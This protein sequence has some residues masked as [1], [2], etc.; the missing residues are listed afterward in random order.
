[1]PLGTLLRLLVRPLKRTPSKARPA[2]RLRLEVLEGRTMPSVSTWVGGAHGDATNWSNA[3]NWSNGVPGANDTAYFPRLDSGVK[4]DL[5]VL[6][7]PAKVANLLIDGRWKSYLQLNASLEVRN[8]FE[9]GSGSLGGTGRLTIDHT[10][11]WSAGLLYGSGALSVLDG[12]T[13]TIGSSATRELRG[14]VIDNAG[15]VYLRD[16]AT[17]LFSSNSTF[18]NHADA[19]FRIT[20]RGTF[21][22]TD[23]PNPAFVN[24]GTVIADTGTETAVI[25]IPFGDGLAGAVD[26]L[27]G[28]LSLRD[29]GK[30]SGVFR[31]EPAGVLEF[32]GGTHV[33]DRFSHV[34]GPGHVRFGRGGTAALRGEY[35]VAATDILGG[36]ADFEAAARTSSATLDNLLFGGNLAGKGTLVVTRSFDWRGGSMT[37]GGTT[38]ITPGATLTLEGARAKNLNA[39][40]IENYGAAVWKDAGDLLWT[41]VGTFDNHAGATFT[42]LNDARMGRADNPRPKFVNDGTFVKAGGLGATTIDV[43]FDDNGSVV[44]AVGSIVFSDGG[45]SKGTFAIGPVGLVTFTG[46][47]ATW[48]AGTKFTGAG[49]VR[50]SGATVHI[51]GA[52]AVANLILDRSSL[53]GPGT[54]VVSKSFD[55]NGG[56]LRN[57]GSL[58]IDASATATL[59]GSAEKVLE[60]TALN[61]AGK[62]V[63]ADAGNLRLVS[64]ASVNVLAGGSLTIDGGAVLGGTGTFANAGQVTKA[65]GGAT[66]LRVPFTNR[67]TLTLGRG[68]VLVVDGGFQQ[69]ATGR[70]VLQGGNTSAS[71]G[72]LAMSSAH[73]V[74]LGGGVSISFATVTDA[75]AIA[76]LDNQTTQLV[77][78]TFAGLPEGSLL[79]LNGKQVRITYK[80]GR[81]GSVLVMPV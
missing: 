4:S 50:V 48:G 72:H 1:M 71:L 77:G 18:V 69:T 31:V 64:G 5:C 80:G 24:D 79:S 43:P 56:T 49:T 23:D 6:G 7:T 14:K 8:D 66:Q 54:L 33:L 41:S 17:V 10:G 68:T 30:D 26:V 45:T 12:A 2:R 34:V 46:G 75:G 11:T 25:D 9:F 39:R 61:L 53:T 35:D 38:V 58:T 37:G 29:G 36:T 44:V 28:T 62:T 57:L 40:T 51:A 22:R 74:T 76:I 15:T 20:G 63:W 59:R 27:S 60:A 32:G 78:G 81:G 67:G 42:V 55:W 70:L 19:V 65:S 47:D 13:F 3:A 16:G 21:G 73:P 52:A